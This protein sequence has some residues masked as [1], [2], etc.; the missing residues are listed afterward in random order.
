MLDP[1]DFADEIAV[2]RD[3]ANLER[4]HACGRISAQAYRRA[5]RRLKARQARM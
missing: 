2:A 3:L 4:D 1:Q 5:R